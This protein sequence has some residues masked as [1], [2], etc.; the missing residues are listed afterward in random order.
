MGQSRMQISTSLGT[1]LGAIQQ[2]LVFIARVTVIF[3]SFL[4]VTKHDILAHKVDISARVTFSAI[5][6]FLSGCFLFGCKSMT[7]GYH[8]NSAV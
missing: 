5:F 7:D 8:L 6:L 2:I 3:T 4:A 1:D